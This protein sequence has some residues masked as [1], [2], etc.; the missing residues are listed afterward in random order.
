[1]SGTYHRG[2]KRALGISSGMAAS[3]ATVWLIVRCR[4]FR[5]E[6]RGDSMAPTLLPGDSA[7]A[8]SVGT[9]ARGHVVV[10]EHPERP[11]F[12]I[13]KRIVGVPGDLTP[14]G[15]ILGPD[16]YWIEGDNPSRS[17]DSRQHGPVRV[18]LIKARVRVIYRPASR[19]RLVSSRRAL[20]A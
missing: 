20:R 16:E 18:D 8:V 2:W 9:P 3:L 11:G 5:V 12:E 10:V 17:T 19:R 6:I 7:L 15:R 4:P 14:D 13:V 1:M